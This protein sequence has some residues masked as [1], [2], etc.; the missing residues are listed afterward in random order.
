MRERSSVAHE[1]TLRALAAFDA[2]LAS[3]LS[4]DVEGAKLEA[5]RAHVQAARALGPSKEDEAQLAGIDASLDSAAADAREVA[6]LDSESRAARSELAE[7]EKTVRVAVDLDAELSR[8]RH[9]PR[10]DPGDVPR[11]TAAIGEEPD[12]EPPMSDPRGR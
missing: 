9:P 4:A 12:D 8:L 7:L 2:L 3:P 1:E 10:S 11:C 5:V 6:R